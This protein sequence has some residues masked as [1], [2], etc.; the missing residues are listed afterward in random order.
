VSVRELASPAPHRLVKYPFVS[1]LLRVPTGF[2]GRRWRVRCQLSAAD[3]AGL[4]ALRTALRELVGVEE[5]LTVNGESFAPVVMSTAPS[6]GPV[7]AGESRCVQSVA[8]DL[9]QLRTEEIG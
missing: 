1:G 6:F 4:V 3:T 9:L 5:V 7:N 8:F 2:A